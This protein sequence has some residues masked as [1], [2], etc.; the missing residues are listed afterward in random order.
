[1]IDNFD[2]IKKF[3]QDNDESTDPDK[4]LFGQI[5]KR[6]KDGH[7]KD[8]VLKDLVFINPNDLVFKRHD[9]IRICYNLN[10]RAY[11]HISPRS[12][13]QVAIQ[14]A[15]S[16]L[17][18]IEQGKESQIRSVFAKACG[19]ISG[20]PKYWTIDVDNL[21]E[22]RDIKDMVPD[23]KLEVPTKNGMHIVTKGFD[24]RDFKT[25]FPDVEIHKN[26]PTLLFA[27]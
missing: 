17:D 5:W 27:L 4:F 10:A 3:Y 12:F 21:S 15:K 16:A 24:T 1:M 13:R 19:N 11:I 26:N 20:N 18:L 2:L 25:V 6:K 7:E 14:V 8:S 9:I 22:I 23:I